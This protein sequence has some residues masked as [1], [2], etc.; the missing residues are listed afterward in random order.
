MKNWLKI[1]DRERWVDPKI[2]ATRYPKGK[3]MAIFA[4]PCKEN[5]QVRK[6]HN[7]SLDRLEKAVREYLRDLE[8]DNSYLKK[9]IQRR[10][11]ESAG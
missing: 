2:L 10:N 7:D 6:L 4:M 8:V 5:E 3:G 11:G 1:I 9:I